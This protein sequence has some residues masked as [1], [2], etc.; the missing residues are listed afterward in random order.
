LYIK[1]KNDLDNIVKK[2]TEKIK[3]EA[4]ILFGS[5]ANGKPHEYSD[6]DFL[7]VIDKKKL[8][9]KERINLEYSIR[10][11]LYETGVPVDLIIKG[12]E[13]IREWGNVEGSI[14]QVA[15][16]NGKILYEREK[17]KISKALAG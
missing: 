1:N 3:P 4:I 8:R 15:V 16:K 9:R 11:I 12:T 2:I 5:Y 14:T 13:E 6:L 10:K 17:G 7:I